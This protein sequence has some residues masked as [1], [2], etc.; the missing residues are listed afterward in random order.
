[1]KVFAAQLANANR[2]ALS[3]P[4]VI[5]GFVKVGQSATHLVTPFMVID[6]WPT[7]HTHAACEVEPAGLTEPD[8]QFAH[9]EVPPVPYVLLPHCWHVPVASRAKPAEQDDAL[10]VV[11]VVERGYIAVAPALF[12]QVQ[13]VISVEPIALAEPV[14]QDVQDVALPAL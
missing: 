13:A 3:E 4:C 9:C 6:V 14:G 8:G 5:G 10:H 11:F 12:A 1:L 2:I 7:G